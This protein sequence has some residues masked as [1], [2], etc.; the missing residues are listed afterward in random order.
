MTQSNQSRLQRAPDF[1]GGR[2]E[3]FNDVWLRHGLPG[4]ALALLLLLLF[5]DQLLRYLWVPKELLPTYLLVGVGVGLLLSLY[6]WRAEGR[7]GWRQF[8]WVLYLGALSFWEE[9]IFRL[10]LPEIGQSFGINHLAA[11]VVSNLL[12]GAV[13][14]FTLRWRWQWCLG[15]AVASLGLSRH[16][17]VHENIWLISVFHWIGTLINTPRLPANSRL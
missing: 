3:S 1:T 11:V 2:L 8:G 17:E 15:A 5:Q 7:L 13:H 6:A 16:F 10:A 4:L 12:F 14:Y 9:W